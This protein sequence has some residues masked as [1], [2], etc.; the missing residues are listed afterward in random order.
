MLAQGVLAFPAASVYVCQGPRILL[1]SL[2]LAYR[3]ALY[4]SWLSCAGFGTM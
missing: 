4:L 2:L 3:L 1:A